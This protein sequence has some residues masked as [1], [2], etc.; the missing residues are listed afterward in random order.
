M[1]RRR[2]L[3]PGQTFGSL[4]IIRPKRGSKGV[5]R[6]KCSCGR[7]R[8]LTTEAVLNSES[9]VC[10]CRPWREQA[11][12]CNKSYR[13]WLDMMRRCY[14][15]EFIGYKNYGGRGIRVCER[16]HVFENFY[17]D[18]GDRPNGLS[19][20]R[21][22]NNGDYEPG[23]CRWATTQEQGNNKRTCN[24]ITFNGRT[25]TTTQW[26]RLLGVYPH[27]IMKSLQKGKLIGD[28]VYRICKR[29]PDKLRLL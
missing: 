27:A 19:I 16:W 4:T 26:E 3:H 2:V 10:K 23:N 17:E 21:I 18:M 6:C 29:D 5:W 22:D 8:T 15:S 12:T 25:L 9:N 28:I 20:D 13:T 1:G 24:Y 14:N 11:R 7:R